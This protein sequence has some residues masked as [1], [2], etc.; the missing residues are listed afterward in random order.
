MMNSLLLGNKFQVLHF[1]LGGVRFCME[2]KYIEKISPLVLLEVVPNSPPYLAGLMN[3]AGKSIPVVDLAIRLGFKHNE[4]YSLNTPI[5]LCS[6]NSRETGLIIDQIIGL[7]YI[8]ADA[9]QMREEFSN[10]NSLFLAAITLETEVALLIN[11]SRVLNFNIAG[12]KKALIETREAS[13]EY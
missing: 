2:I 4:S 11:T 6:E 12:E 1:L 9:I 5:L 7:D 13:G 8:E 3:H 10:E